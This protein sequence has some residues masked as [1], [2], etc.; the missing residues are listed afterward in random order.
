MHHSHHRNPTLSSAAVFDP[1]LCGKTSGSHSIASIPSLRELL[2]SRPTLRPF[3]PSPT[4]TIVGWNG[5]TGDDIIEAS[6]PDAEEM[7][8]PPSPTRTG[9]KRKLSNS[10]TT[11]AK[12][13][14]NGQRQQDAHH[15]PSR[16]CWHRTLTI[17]DNGTPV[18]SSAPG[19]V[20]LPP[21][22]TSEAPNFTNAMNYTRAGGENRSRLAGYWFDQPRRM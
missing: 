8:S 1:T 14:Y 9:T 16:A 3:T 19:R 22:R 20:L 7:V 5:N 15:A 18:F 10:F 6:D 11:D 12:P 21:M 17:D 4:A 13:L 2:G